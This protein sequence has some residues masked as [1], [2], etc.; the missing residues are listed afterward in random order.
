MHHRI[1]LVTSLLLLAAACGRSDPA[2][3]TAPQPPDLGRTAS[4]L[5]GEPDAG[6]PAVGAVLFDQAL[7]S[8]TLI[9]PNVVLTAAHC[10]EAGTPR[11]FVLGS[12]LTGATAVLA[13]RSASAHPDYSTHHEKGA[14]I[15]WHDV[16]ALVL[17][18]AAPVAPMPWRAASMAG[19]VG[20]VFTFVG[21]G[22]TDPATDSAGSKFKV[23]SKIAA[24]WS[25]GFWNVTSPSDPKNTCHGDSG[26]PALLVEDG[27]EQVAGVV[28]SGD[29][30]C[31][32]T[33]YSTRVDVNADYIA[34]VIAANPPD[35]EADVDAPDAVG[36]DA[37]AT[38]PD[39]PP[40]PAPC[41][42]VDFAGCCD[43][44]TVRWCEDGE[45]NSMTCADN[46]SCGWDAIDHYYDC[47]TDGRADP[48]GKHPRAC[49]K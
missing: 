44:Q 45:V 23:G 11:Y 7:C 41:P 43:G 46:P 37:S 39:T 29:A 16:A 28:S 8:G 13:V 22:Q 33:G 1:A 49:G 19:T 36:P 20:R 12:T 15:N 34:G 17:D 42:G 32:E 38:G 24:V 9:A 25:Q 5:G 47:G 30:G 31:V 21:Y 35:G 2:P 18:R 27:V 6:H 26:G 3:V 14:L 40:T 4:I 10:L 48:D